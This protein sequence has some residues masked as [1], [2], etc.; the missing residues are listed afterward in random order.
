MSRKVELNA[1]LTRSFPLVKLL[2]IILSRSWHQ[3]SLLQ[4][5]NVLVNSYSYLFIVPG[6]VESHICNSFLILPDFLTIANYALSGGPIALGFD[7]NWL[8]L[9][10]VFVLNARVRREHSI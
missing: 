2:Y 9:V 10:V 4:S 3:N 1:L 5:R 7:C 6:K 8:E